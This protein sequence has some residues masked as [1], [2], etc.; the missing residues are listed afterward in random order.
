MKFDRESLF[1]WIANTSREKSKFLLVAASILAG[2]SILLVARLDFHSDVANLLPSSAPR[3]QA[4]VKFLKEFGA[5]DSLFIILERK[6]GQEM[7]PFLPF[8]ESLAE[9][10]MATG[11]ITEIQGRM[12][13]AV[14]EKIVEGLI[15]K[16]F[17]Y[18]TEEDLAKLQAKLSEEGI[19]KEIIERKAG[20]HSPLGSFKTQWVTR[21][22]LNLW[23]LFQKHL[24][25]G[26]SQG[27]MDS[28]G[29]FLSPDRK[30]LLLIARPKGS[31]VDVDYDEKLLR[32]VREAEQAAKEA[33][34]KKEPPAPDVHLQDLTLGLAGGY[35][36]AL[37]DRRMIR[38]ELIM[39]FS[40]SLLAVLA[41]FFF[42]FRRWTAIFYAIVPLMLSPLLTLGFF[43]PFLGRLSESTGA[44]SAIILGLSIDFVILL[45]GR[46][47]EERRSGLDLS[48]A[49][50]KS[51]IQTGPG[52]F[53][54]AVTT[55]AAYYI[56]LFSDFRGIRELGALTGTGIL[57][58]ML[59]AFILFPALL[60]LGRGG[61]KERASFRGMSAFG[62]E[63]ITIPA[64]RRPG[65][66][67]FISAA[68]SIAASFFAFQ[69]KINNDPRS[70]RPP[71]H[72][73]LVWE[74]RMQEKMEQ[75]Q[76]TVIILKESPSLNQA[77]EFQGDLKRKLEQATFSKIPL[78]GFETLASFIPPPSRQ[79]R[80]LEWIAAREKEVFDPN[81]VEKTLRRT[82]EQEG[83][84]VEPFEP[85]ITML[86][87]ILTNREMLTV[88][89]MQGSPLG[90]LF[91]RFLKKEG[92]SYWTAAY[93]HIRPDFWQDENA[94]SFLKG[95]SRSTPDL[96][97]TGSKL[98]QMELEDL[99]AREA[100]LILVLSFLAVSILIGLD[101]RS[102]RLT[103]LSLIPVILAS[104]W[105]LGIMGLL[106]LDLN[107]MNLIVF[108]MVL[109]I[110]V[111][112][113]VHVLHRLQ[114]SR[115]SNWKE[116]L[117]QVS[118][119]VILAALTTLAGFGSLV[120][121][122]YPGLRS[123]GSVALMG[124]GFSALLALTLVPCLA[125]WMI[126]RRQ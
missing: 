84:R 63:A 41:L 75:G 34:G 93:L 88:P 77:L 48:M 76:E 111:D 109:G 12:D 100:W 2:I 94:Q 105:T 56:L 52:I 122:G 16:A 64:L 14:L 61:K 87:K 86:R 33:F 92:D 11:E 51:L 125:A 30:M 53:T 90:P 32:K 81:R 91:E 57:L 118:R 38:R 35:M 42:A 95:L 59:C 102:L 65:L 110:G 69:V 104:I 17:L 101:F 7:D 113:G 43:S 26:S 21:D 47:L 13:S 39:N 85:A 83:L 114:E 36:N 4:F 82:L 46:Y 126:S 112:Y 1:R 5:A 44:F 31:A 108:S 54:G 68:L 89:A 124:V 103:L 80:N 19:R 40:I 62:L 97:V 3:T 106:G 25:A 119:G 37:E 20:L 98:V 115:D 45:Y 78:A 121:S 9:K 58:S 71:S 23:S 55:A 10:L 73:A 99:M 116:G 79:R 6:S 72:S 24:P 27:E 70:L 29:I 66:V 15:P 67:I 123:M 117:G 96:L 74:G 50:E 8:A 60:A 49:L 120:L 107:F 22:P 28:K 18:L